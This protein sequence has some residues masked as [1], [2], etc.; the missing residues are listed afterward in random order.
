MELVSQ[1]SRVRMEKQRVEQYRKHLVRKREDLLAVLQRAEKE[2]RSVDEEGTQDLAD[3]AASAYT[4]EFLFHQ[5]S[6]ERTLLQM[7]DEALARIEE[8]R[9][10]Q[11]QHCG[12][13]MLAKR[14]D[15]VPW[16]RHCVTCQELEDQG[17]L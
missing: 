13:P 4:K 1:G 5:S 6:N 14:L 3:K 7:I 9:F 2:G 8:G 15:A 12:G 17:L 10:G 11:C 16:A